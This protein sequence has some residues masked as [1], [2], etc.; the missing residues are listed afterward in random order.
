MTTIT[1]FVVIY[2]NNDND[3][4]DDDNLGILMSIVLTHST[5][6]TLKMWVFQL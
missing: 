4:D 2:G 5:S 6:M 3:N 1:I